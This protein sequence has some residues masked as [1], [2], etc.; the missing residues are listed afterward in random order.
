MDGQGIGLDILDFDDW[1][2][3]DYEVGSP[4]VSTREEML[5]SFADAVAHLTRAVRLIEAKNAVIFELEAEIADLRHKLRQ[6]MS[7][8]NDLR[9]ILGSSRQWAVGQ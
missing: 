1:R 8:Q 5:V 3:E 9:K 6:A 7:R 4:P 2:G